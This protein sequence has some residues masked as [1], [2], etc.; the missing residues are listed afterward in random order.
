L[1][2]VGAL[3]EYAHSLVGF[4]IWQVLDDLPKSMAVY[5]QLLGGE[6]I[7]HPI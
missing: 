3:V 1:K 6:A 2:S 4:N 7:L 5:T